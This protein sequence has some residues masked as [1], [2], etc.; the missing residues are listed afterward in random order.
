[1]SGCLGATSSAAI[2]ATSSGDISDAA[3]GVFLAVYVL[4]D[5]RAEAVSS[6]GIAPNMRVSDRFVSDTAR[7]N[8]SFGCR[9]LGSL[10][11]GATRTPR[12]C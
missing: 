2:Y 11:H 7:T 3:W 12:R 1:M 8:L 9:D 5:D 4:E 10:T 6:S